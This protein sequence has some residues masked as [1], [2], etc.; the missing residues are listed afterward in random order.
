M[1]SCTKRDDK[2]ILKCVVPWERKL[3]GNKGAI[4]DSV[5]FT[6]TF[7]HHQKE[8][9]QRNVCA[10]KHYVMI[11][12]VKGKAFRNMQGESILKSLLNGETDSHYE[13]TKVSQGN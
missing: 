7:V 3:F 13:D 10:V 2:N 6:I 11:E 4:F 9:A 5:M 8:I 12:L 1:S